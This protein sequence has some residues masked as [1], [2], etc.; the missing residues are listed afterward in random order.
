[1]VAEV[2]PSGRFLL[3]LDTSHHLLTVLRLERL[4][5]VQVTDGGGRVATA[6]LVEVRGKQAA[7]EILSLIEVAAPLRRVVVLGIPKGPLLEEALTLGTEAGATEFRLVQARYSQP[8]YLKMERLERVL[9]MSATQCKRSFLPTLS[10]PLRLEE[11]L[12]DLPEIRW[13]GAQGAPVREGTPEEAALAIGPE[14]GWAAEE[15]LYLEDQGFVA[16]GLGP[17]VLRNPTA[18]AVGLARLYA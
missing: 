11:A 17:F 10:G 3:D 6:R 5:Q 15:Q 12:A 2:P 7:L 18:V 16:V 1:M 8:S 14:G 13:L 4:G 9:R